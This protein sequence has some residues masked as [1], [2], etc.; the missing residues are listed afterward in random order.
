VVENLC[1][2]NLF[3]KEN[4]YKMQVSIPVLKFFATISEMHSQVC[5]LRNHFRSLRLTLE[6][7]NGRQGSLKCVGL[8]IPMNTTVSR[9]SHQSNSVIQSQFI[10]RIFAL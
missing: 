7:A 4:F 9:D 2:Y 1:F 3:R 10:K 8:H 6:N 5:D